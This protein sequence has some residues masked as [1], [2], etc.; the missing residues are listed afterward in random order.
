MENQVQTD[1]FNLTGV[2]AG[3]VK[4]AMKDA[5][6]TSRDLWYVPINEIVQ[7]PDFNVRVKNEDYFASVRAIADSIK[8][9]GFYPHKPIACMVI[10]QDGKDVLACIDGHTRLDAALLAKS[11][12][13]P[14]DK[15]PVVTTGA[16]MTLEDAVV[17][18]KVSNSSNPLTPMALGVICKRLS[19]FGWSNTKIAEKL[20]FSVAYVGQLLQ[21]VGAE[22]VIRDLV[23][24]D[25]IS[26]TLAVQVMNSEGEHAADVLKQAVRTAEEQGKCKATAKHVK[27]TSGPKKTAPAPETKVIK[28][29]EPVDNSTVMPLMQSPSVMPFDA[30]FAAESQRTIEISLQEKGVA[31]LKNNNGIVDH[32]HYELF[33]AMTGA[34]L[35]VLKDMLK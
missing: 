13:V 33:I 20:V 32:S 9:N 34:S 21:L 6:A 30:L 26:S 24:E 31:W 25:K 4:S 19:G 7:L 2:T 16:G 17:N 12:D 8:A 18:L 5:G 11:E 15:L 10:K 27:R 1:N 29:S 14:L 28:E 3:S 22:K 23:N 35:E